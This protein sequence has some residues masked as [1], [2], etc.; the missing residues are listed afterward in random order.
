MEPVE[1]ASTSI[2]EAACRGADLGDLVPAGVAEIIA[3][4]GLYREGKC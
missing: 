2:R 3:A 1:L 4:E